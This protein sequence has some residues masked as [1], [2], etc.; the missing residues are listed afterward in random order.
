MV[1]S[2]DNRRTDFAMCHKIIENFSHRSPLS[3]AE[4]ANSRRQSLKRNSFLSLLYPVTQRRV[5]GKRFHH[6]AVGSVDIRGIA[7]QCRPPERAFAVAEQRANVLWYKPWYVERLL[8]AVSE[9][10]AANIISIIEH[11]GPFF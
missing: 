10:L 9:R 2:D 7:R 1:A 5:V 4:P 11:N 8:H 3:V 6:G